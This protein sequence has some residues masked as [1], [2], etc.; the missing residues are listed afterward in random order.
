MIKAHA[1]DVALATWRAER[2]KSVVGEVLV[3]KALQRLTAA[4]LALPLFES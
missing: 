3:Y 1:R 2:V 4:H